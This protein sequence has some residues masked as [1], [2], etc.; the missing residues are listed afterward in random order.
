MPSVKWLKEKVS[1]FSPRRIGF[2]RYPWHQSPHGAL[3]SRSAK[4]AIVNIDYMNM[5][6]KNEVGCCM[7]I[8]HTSLTRVNSLFT[9]GLAAFNAHEEGQRDGILPTTPCRIAT[10]HCHW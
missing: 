8:E 9:I 1:R 3:I 6:T 10:C 7:T 2:F 4:I 5:I